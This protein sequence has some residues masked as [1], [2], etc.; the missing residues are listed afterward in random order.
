MGSQYISLTFD[1]ENDCSF[2]SFKGVEI[3][4][5]KTLRLLEKF[6]IPATFFV[7]GEVAELFPKVIQELGE[8][9]EVACHG[10]HHESFQN[11]NPE[12]V[13][14]LKTAKQVIE[15]TINKKIL[16]FRAPY[17]R[18]D[19]ELF[20]T[21]VKLGFKYDSSLAFYKTSQ[22]H[23]N[24]PIIEFRLLFPNVYF[25][26]PLGPT[27]FKLGC[28]LER[29]PVL[30]FHP[31]EALDV[32]SLLIKRG[33]YFRNIITR[34]D[35]WFN[36]GTKFLSSLARLIQYFSH[37]GFTFKTLENIYLHVHCNH[38]T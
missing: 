37:R 30:Y 22:W 16:G 8:Q 6:N 29:T 25:R 4:L 34:P 24:P 27:L 3:G 36:S 11:I 17:L 5:P 26:F 7:T 15:E 1:V 2:E 35:R 23:L 31:W 33:N 13:R 19:P 14:I 9:Y 21:L 12:K 10:Y 28:L 20:R 32:R 18:I 38:E